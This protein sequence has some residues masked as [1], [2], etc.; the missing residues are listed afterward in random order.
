MLAHENT[1]E[2]L[3]ISQLKPIDAAKE[4]V[5]ILEL[6]ERLCPEGLH[7]VGQNFE[8]RCPLP[9][10][11]DKSPSFYV[12]PATE[13]CWCFGCQRGGDVVNLAALAWGYGKDEQAMA[14]ANLLHEF[15]HEIPQRPP[16]W[17]ARQERQKPIRD[18]LEETR[19]RSVRRRMYRIFVR[20][21]ISL[22][23]DED[24]RREEA[25][26]IWDELLPI[27]R[28]LVARGGWA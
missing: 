15:G 3:P 27:A 23:E 9:G 28:M 5:T 21:S 14:A 10:H 17:F 18:A 16:S 11:D 8:A 26:K 25:E 22:I 13:S 1:T 20:N 24:E 12:Y 2:R 6:A 7:R 19:V 4:R